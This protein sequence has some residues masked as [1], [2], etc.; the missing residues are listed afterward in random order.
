MRRTAAGRRYAPW[1]AAVVWLAAGVPASGAAP[2]EACA[3]LVSPRDVSLDGTFRVLAAS[4]TPYPDAAWELHGPGFVLPGSRPRR[5]GGPPYWWSAEFKVSR[6]GE[7]E[8]S[9]VSRGKPL[10]GRSLTIPSAAPPP[11]G[12]TG[13]W[14]IERGWDRG[15]EDLYA[16]WIEALFQE[17]DEG[18]S[19][20]ALQDVLRDAR[21]NI[22]YDRLGLGEDD[23]DGRAAL[24]LRPDCADNPFFLRAYFAWKLGLPFGFRECTR[25][26]LS[27]P[28]R[29][30]RWITN[31][32]G[33]SAGG[34]L[35][36]FRSF[37]G[38]IMN[39]I[40]SATGRTALADEETDLYPVAL[41]RPSL[42][43][44][45][46]FADPFGHTLVLVRWLDQT[47]DRPGRL[48]AVD[49]QPDGT[50][51]LRR[52]WRGNFLFATSEVVGEPGFKAFRPIVLDGGR[53]RPLRNAEIRGAAAAA[54][55]S[56]EQKAMA[57]DLF[58]DRMDRLINPEPL[59]PAGAWRDLVTAL[60]EQCLARVLSVANGEDYLKAHPGE[61]IPMPTAP[62]AVFL[63]IGPWEDF[64]TPNRDMRLLI[65][66]DAVLD[67][68]ARFRKAPDRFRLPV[69]KDPD[70]MMA[71]LTALY[72]DWTRELSI[73]YIRSN[74]AERVLTLEEI[75][76]RREDFE[77][78]Y[79]P[80][81]CIEIRWAEPEG[82]PESSSCRRRAPAAQREWMKALRPW[83]AKRL[84]PAG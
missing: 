52:F 10:A 49:A 81:D 4:G 36:A 47:R 19:W 76:N 42:R 28:P 26:S 84:H 33:A 5:G 45:T 13:V 12:G 69:G 66:M 46:V 15:E 48:L 21:R 34:P 27:R 75:L 60:H 31:A 78:A 64:A 6:P 32:D 71:E 14:P 35:R 56:L 51:G 3:I 68:P 82:G 8:V 29:C 80:N 77:M 72:R 20:P 55:F 59:D 22:L 54:P 44:G 83:F 40:H 41:D 37:L 57:P 58:Y 2:A 62:S 73:R 50:V 1:L 25:G 7:Y 18:A 63:T 23:P 9:L 61:V 79:N 74:G 24:E 38:R 30:D 43:P 17:D 39:A 70:R 16:A 11:A 53:L 65:A 67:F